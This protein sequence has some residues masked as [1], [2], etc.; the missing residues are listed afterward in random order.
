MPVLVRLLRLL[1][2]GKDLIPDLFNLFVNKL[3]YYFFLRTRW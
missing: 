1:E 2:F 3:Q